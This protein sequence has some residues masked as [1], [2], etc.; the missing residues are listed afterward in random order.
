MSLIRTGHTLCDLQYDWS[1]QLFIMI[2]LEQLL[3]FE[4]DNFQN[5]YRK[6][7]EKASFSAHVFHIKLFI[8]TAGANRE[9]V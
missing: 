1:K 7:L 2:F 3:S 4:T 5:N 6:V 8:K 9:K